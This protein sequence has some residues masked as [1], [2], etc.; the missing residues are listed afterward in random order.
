MLSTRCKIISD[1]HIM[2]GKEN[3]GELHL[4]ACP[5][6]PC[7]VRMNMG[8]G[9]PLQALENI[10]YRHQWNNIEK[11]FLS[12]KPQS[13]LSSSGFTVHIQLPKSKRI[14]CFERHL[15]PWFLFLG[16]FRLAVRMSPC[17]SHNQALQNYMP[18][19]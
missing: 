12:G 4:N 19:H 9:R 5:S 6:S 13:H 8:P 16:F 3:N 14:A 15:F 2:K 17:F 10:N 7:C 11:Q 1:Y 18:V